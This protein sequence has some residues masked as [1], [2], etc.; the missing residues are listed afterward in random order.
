MGGRLLRRAVVA[1]RQGGAA[2]AQL[3]DGV[4]LGDLVVLLIQ[5]EHV[6]VGEMPADGNAARIVPLRLQNMVGTVAGD[7]RG[8][9]Q[10]HEHSLR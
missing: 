10:V 3:T 2:D 9:V 8:A 1:Q 5:Q 6:L 4:R 7:F